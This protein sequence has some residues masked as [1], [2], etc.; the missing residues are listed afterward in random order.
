MTE[1][2]EALLVAVDVSADAADLE[3]RLRRMGMK[4][5]SLVD[6]LDRLRQAADET[7]H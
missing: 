1:T 2:E 4:L 7:D 6:H 5:S 3:A